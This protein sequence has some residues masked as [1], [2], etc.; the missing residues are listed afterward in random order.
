MRA[1]RLAAL[2]VGAFAILIAAPPAHAQKTLELMSWQGE[3]P[4]FSDWWKQ[5]IAAFNQAHPQ[6]PVKMTSI[7][8]KDYLDQLTIRF[9]SNRPPPLLELPTD[10]L[11]AFAS[12][13]WLQ[14]LDDRIK[15]TAIATD[16]SSLQR[17]LTWDGKT[18]GVLLMGYAFM[19]FY[20]QQLLDA[21]GITAPPATL[22][23]W[24]ADVGRITDRDKGIFGL[25]AVT[26]EYPTLPLDF[27]RMIVWN[28]GALVKDGHY[29][30]TDAKTVAAI[31]DYRRVVAG[32]APLG[33]NSTIIRQLFTDGKSGFLIDGPWV[34]QLV[35]KAKPEV[36]ANLRMAKAPFQ[37]PLGGASNS[38][39]MAAGLDRATQD[40]AWSFIAFLAQPEWQQKYTVLTASPAALKGAV[41]PEIAKEH[42][43]L[44]AINE[45]VIGAQSTTPASQALRS[46]YNEFSKIIQRTAMQVLST[47]EPVAD[48]LK[49]AQAQLEQQVPLQQ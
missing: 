43:E 44:V 38:I 30:L 21:A 7:P 4:G 5:V 39:H 31:E 23:E 37:P 17:D 41:T 1:R 46:N 19:M 32:N 8:F 40:A 16:W 9:A 25:S 48:I 35:Q 24:E 3:E 45:A 42:P 13:G 20:N 47:R 6:A 12:Q 49:R 18:Q 15:G 10:S 36:R 34:W 22:R 26:T 33:D 27:I 28:G 14:P 29:N 11:G 2:F